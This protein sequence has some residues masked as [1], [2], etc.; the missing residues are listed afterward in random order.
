M[1]S[2]MFAGIVGFFISVISYGIGYLGGYRNGK[3]IGKLI[4][5]TDAFKATNAV[6]ANLNDGLSKMV[7]NR[8]DHLLKNA[9]FD[10]N[11]SNLN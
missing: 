2:G 1:D 4:G 11:N 7:K 5:A 6:L 3:E 9:T 10:K 8:E